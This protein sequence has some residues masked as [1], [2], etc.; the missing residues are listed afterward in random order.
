MLKKT[1]TDFYPAHNNKYTLPSSCKVTKQNMQGK[2]SDKDPT[3]GKFLKPQLSTEQ[4]EI[5]RTYLQVAAQNIKITSKGSQDAPPRPSR[6]PTASVGTHATL[7]QQKQIVYNPL[8]S[9]EHRRPSDIPP[10]NY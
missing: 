1:L 6:T 9:N 4:P 2:L 3:L 8:A 5:N 7:P 10:A